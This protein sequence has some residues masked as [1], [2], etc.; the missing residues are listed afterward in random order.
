MPVPVSSVGEITPKRIYNVHFLICFK[1]LIYLLT[2]RKKAGETTQP[3]GMGGPKQAAIDPVQL[4]HR[5]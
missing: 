4:H 1:M 2:Y 3:W 5:R